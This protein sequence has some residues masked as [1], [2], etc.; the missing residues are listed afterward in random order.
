MASDDIHELSERP[1]LPLPARRGSDGLLRAEPVRY[2]RHTLQGLDVA[3]VRAKPYGK[4]KYLRINRIVHLWDSS[5]SE[6]LHCMQRVPSF[7]ED[8]TRETDEITCVMC[9]GNIC[10]PFMRVH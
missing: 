7:Y 4:W 3:R 2:R 8:V 9:C 1:A 6:F 5:Q 10:K